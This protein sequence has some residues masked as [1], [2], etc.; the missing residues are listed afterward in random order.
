[1]GR[2]STPAAAALPRLAAPFAA[3]G[4]DR[5]TALIQYER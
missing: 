1:M 2:V 5:G 3:D 4:M